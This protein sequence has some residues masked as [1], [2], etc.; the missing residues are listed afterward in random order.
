[1]TGKRGQLAKSAGT[2]IGS[3][4]KQLH[5][6]FGHVVDSSHSSQVS[7]FSSMDRSQCKML[8]CWGFYGLAAVYGGK[9]IDVSSLLFDA[10]PGQCW[11]PEPWLQDVVVLE[12]VCMRINGTFR[13]RSC[14]RV[15]MDNK[16]WD[17]LTCSMCAIILFQT[18]FKFRVLREDKCLTKRG[19]RSTKGGRRI[20]YLSLP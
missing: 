18:D 14:L 20:G 10:K 13:H 2:S 4:Q 9:V 3:S 19:T 16:P 17:V 8:M 1:M 11:Y 5:A 7:G 12:R 15:S 6:F